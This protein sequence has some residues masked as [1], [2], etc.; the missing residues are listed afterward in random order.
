MNNFERIFPYPII[1]QQTFESNLLTGIW[2]LI[3]IAI[4]ISATV[5]IF[6]RGKQI[7]KSINS[8]SPENEM[9]L[10]SIW[11]AYQSTFSYFG[12]S[13][14][15]SVHAEEYINEN[16]IF[17][18]FLNFRLVNNISNI[19]VGMGILGTFVGLT[20]G[21]SGI[22]TTEGTD[23]L[24]QSIDGLMSG[25]STAFVTSIWGMGLSLGFT[26]FFK[27]WQTR[28]FRTI[29][30]M[31]FRLDEEF[32][33][34]EDDLQ[35]HSDQK[36]KEI[37]SELFNEYLV[38]E[39][40][41]GKQLPKNVFR[42]ILEES[43]K[44]TASLQSFSDDLADSITAAMELMVSENNT[45]L[46]NL[47]EEKL[48]P[49][50]N[51]LKEI[52]QDSGTKIIEDAVKRLSDSMKEMLHEFKSSITGDTKNELEGLAARLTTVSEALTNVPNTMA[53]ISLQVSEMIEA[54][55]ET[56]IE[57]IKASKSEAAAQSEETRQ[58]FISAKEDYSNSVEDIQAHMELM[59]SNQKDNIKHVSDLTD[60]IKETLTHNSQVN[61]Q[62]EGLVQKTKEISLTFERLTSSLYNNSQQISATSNDLHK[63]T[64]EFNS[65]IENYLKKNHELIGSQREILTKTV[66]VS[67]QYVDK[68]NIIESGL[69]G[70]FNQVQLG[71]KDYQTTT[72]EN[73]NR[74]LREF[75]TQLTSAQNG[76][77]SNISNLSE[78]AEELTEQVEKFNT[79]R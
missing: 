47:I 4:A 9:N 22:K 79:R 62:F 60:K 17:H 69:K 25:M 51:D 1:N 64:H 52:K 12:N 39:T 5:Y 55:R 23:Q 35:K 58:A 34:S 37:I 49:V 26:A 61:Q 73:L 27:F 36:Q 10:K 70:I 50:L 74:Y 66:E 38:A 63:S 7:T 77:E 6:S 59:L 75:T 48:V 16:T 56:V 42:R 46:S 53:D 18:A 20:I 41:E 28:I 68:F 54:L 15:T 76:L 13:K 29:Q 72:A 65:G 19:L 11:D 14:K 40:S 32:K 43:E 33:I 45:Q 78:I 71:L 30:N 3:T 44:Q 67:N 21:I 2:V 24:A 8:N 57:N 31:C